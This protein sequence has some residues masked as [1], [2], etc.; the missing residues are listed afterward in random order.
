MLYNKNNINNNSNIN[1]NL[2]NKKYN[3]NFNTLLNEFKLCPINNSND[4]A[5]ININ[6]CVI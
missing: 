1:S 6:K 2:N 4:I 3:N 5:D